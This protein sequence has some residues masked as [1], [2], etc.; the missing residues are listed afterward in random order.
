MKRR[1]RETGACLDRE[2]LGFFY[3]FSS[4]ITGNL[5]LFGKIYV[6][7]TIFNIK[8]YTFGTFNH[9]I[10]YIAVSILGFNYD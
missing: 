1:H 10:R 3:L 9:I 7:I 6:H 2:K 8:F 4:T 5:T